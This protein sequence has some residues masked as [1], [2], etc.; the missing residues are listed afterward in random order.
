MVYCFP[1]LS[2]H[3]IGYFKGDEGL[4]HSCIH[5]G[6]F[7]LAHFGMALLFANLL[8]ILDDFFRSPILLLAV[9]FVGL[10]ALFACHF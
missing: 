7:G 3:D 4:L 2:S 10:A 8:D 6:C 1:I 9:P 5:F